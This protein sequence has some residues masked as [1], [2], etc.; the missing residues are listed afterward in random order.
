[1]KKIYFLVF[2]LFFVFPTNLLAQTFSAEI[3]IDQSGEVSVSNGDRFRINAGVSEDELRYPII[4]S[5]S[6]S[7]QEFRGILKL[8]TPIEN[9]N[10]G[11]FSMIAIN[12]VGN[13][14]VEIIDSTTISYQA[15]GI[16]PNAE[17][18]IIAKFPKGYFNLPPATIVGVGIQAL[19]PLWI[20]SSW[21]IP[22]IGLSLLGYM[23]F[24]R[25]RDH[26]MPSDNNIYNAPPSDIA[27]ALISTLYENKIQ[28]EAI[29]STLIDLARRGYISIFN[30]GNNFIFA[31]E[32]EIDLSTQAFQVGMHDVKLNDEEV[33]IARKEGLK[34]FEKILL[35]KLFVAS[36][37]ISSKEDVKVRIG[38]G[39]FSKKVA[40]IYEYLFRDA[41]ELGYFVPNA[42]SKHRKYLFAGWIL[43]I[44]GFFG[45]LLGVWFLP[46]PKYF[47]L[48]WVALMILA[49]LIIGLAPY[50]PLRTSAGRSQ[51]AKFL[52]FRKYISTQDSSDN[53]KSI[54]DFFKILP[55]AWALGAHHEWAKKFE[56]HVYHRP[57]W[58]YSGKKNQSTIEFVQEIDN[59]IEFVS[60]SFAAVREKTLA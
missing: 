58:Y 55:H 49:N 52:E 33:K 47:I 24:Q 54:D 53:N 59:L 9:A 11:S 38:H 3:N 19:N 36:R 4:D 51:L 21:I 25:F 48:F 12:G 15:I 26:Q 43:A 34:P 57:D 37:P 10:L 13:H 45:F 1:M 42:I 28:P 14:S 20:Y 2:A 17:I 44:L 56:H 31:R 46:D 23:W 27:P 41:S 40:A 29:A 8:P 32:R 39:L 18:T 35:S 16:G 22:F 60:E 6:N 30:K 50:V 7:Y 5:N